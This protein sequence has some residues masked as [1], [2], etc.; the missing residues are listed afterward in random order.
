MEKDIRTSRQ[1]FH[2]S[3]EQRLYLGWEP[4]TDVQTTLKKILDFHLQP[5][6]CYGT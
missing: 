1:E 4:K 3:G 5:E 6:V 2:Q